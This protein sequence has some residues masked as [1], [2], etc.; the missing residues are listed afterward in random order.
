[1]RFPAAI[2]LLLA[3]P[4][5]AALADGV[6]PGWERSARAHLESMSYHFTETPDG[7]AAAA[8]HSQDIR[9]R[10]T[11]DGFRLVSRVHDAA[12]FEV[13]F[14]L[15]GYG[16][17]GAI[18]PV[19]PGT[20]KVHENRA[21]VARAG[22]PT[23]YFVNDERGF[24]H[25]YTVHE[26]PR[27]AKAR[28]VVLALDLATSL[29]IRPH[30]DGRTI[31]FARP[32]EGPAL[33]YTDLMVRDADG[34]ALPA[35]FVQA[36]T[37]LEIRYDDRGAAYPV[38]VDPIATTAWWTVE[39]T[40]AYDWLGWSA[41]A[42]G[43]LNGDGFSDIVIGITGEDEGSGDAGAAWVYYGSAAGLPSQFSPS[44]VGR[45]GLFAGNFGH[46]VSP[47]GDVNG[48]GYGDLIVGQPRDASVSGQRAFVYLGSAT[49]LRASFNNT[50]SLGDWKAVGGPT[51]NGVNAFGWSVASAG[52]VNGDG[53]DDVVVGAPA[54]SPDASTIAAGQALIW[55]GR[56]NFGDPALGT[57]DDGNAGNA[58]G[59]I[60]TG[61]AHRKL[62]QAVAGV[63]DVNAD[64]FDDVVVGAPG[65][66]SNAG[67]IILLTGRNTP[68]GGVN[69]SDQ[70]DG[71]AGSAFGQSVG[72]AG[73][74]NGDGYADVLVGAPAWNGG[75]GQVQLYAGAPSAPFLNFLQ[76]WTGT[77]PGDSLGL[78][79]HTAGDV[80]GDGLADVMIGRGVYKFNGTDP[81]AA[82]LYYGV[83]GGAPSFTPDWSVTGPIYNTIQQSSAYGFSVAS[84][85]DVDGDGY[86][87]FI[88]GAP[89]YGQSEWGHAYVYKGA[90]RAPQAATLSAEG[91]GQENVLG[92]STAIVGDVNWDGYD[93]VLVG[94]PGWDNGIYRQGAAFLYYGTANG[95]NFFPGWQQFGEYNEANFGVSVS[96][97]G[98]VNND[99][100]DDLIIGA[101]VNAGQGGA[102]VWH[103]S[104][105]GPSPGTYNWQNSSSNSGSYYG[106]WVAKAGDVN[107]DG[108]ADVAVGA[109]GEDAG[110]TDEGCAYVYLGSASGLGNA[111]VWKR[112]GNETNLQFGQN[113]CSAGDVNGDGL[114][115]I[116]VGAPGHDGMGGDPRG[117]AFIYNGIA[118]GVRTTP[119]WVKYGPSANSSFGAAASSAGDVNG[120]GYSDVLIG[121]PGHN[122]SGRVEVYHGGYFGP[123]QTPAWF[124]DGQF[125]SGYGAAVA[126]AGDM[127]G[128]GYSD[129]LVG[130]V[131]W[132]GDGG[133][134]CGRAIV[135]PGGPGGVSSTELWH[136]DGIQDFSNLG[137]MVSGGGDVNDDGFPDIVLGEPGYSGV[138]YRSGRAQ[139]FL[140]NGPGGRRLISQVQ[141]CF[142]LCLLQYVSPGGR[143]AAP[144]YS[145]VIIDRSPEGRAI[146][147]A[148][149]EVKTK[150][151]PFTGTGLLTS[152]S[153]DGSGFG[154]AGTP[155]NCP[156][157]QNPC[158]WRIRLT[159]KS[160][161]FPRSP[162]FSLP[163]NGPTESDVRMAG[164]VLAVDP[165]APA[166]ALSLAPS[167][168]P[169]QGP[170]HF[171]YALPEGAMVKLVVRDI[172]GRHVR[173]L[174][175]KWHAPGRYELTWDA[176]DEQGTRCAPGVYFG[177]V[178]AGA[179]RTSSRFSIVH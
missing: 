159:S 132:D 104:A 105:S 67:R 166:P 75:R 86:G 175:N 33:R 66:S 12:G 115:D 39:G 68:T 149:T 85:G 83:L 112:C 17:D 91:Q 134:D 120:D 18:R 109:P 129:I 5:S 114:D 24:E 3:L 36:G 38:D 102:Y 8:N 74:V 20:V 162:W 121:A 95:V 178:E 96:G 176:R 22:V 139:M 131:F 125:S 16:R 88:V 60:G 73:D 157:G 55:L 48:D 172:A 71:P 30:V 100:F 13:G 78:A 58:A 179:Q 31:A 113:V 111:E 10:V 116:I 110:L 4:V 106:Y 46:S 99:G 130:A 59:V 163:H 153:Q 43:D 81:G 11:G 15:A 117:R 124:Q 44:W 26:R 49:G 70:I 146:V 51:F 148:Q 7:M 57:S 54:F 140:G 154:W 141:D 171:A 103:G 80:N 27:G 167:P 160:P 34:D 47:A 37:R 165:G 35:H 135:Y 147:R 145:P 1:M 108:F 177:V 158:H 137:H 32:G 65:W 119:L 155:T 136:A 6:D 164:P 126:P 53:F 123:G 90:P 118:T 169:S 29:E 42:A 127:N 122:G 63:G 151:Q 64:G 84:A 28:E 82:Q 25:G 9:A 152:A 94:S 97:A 19:A 98:D 45:T 61:V 144:G 168:N 77:S 156:G 89:H 76:S 62:G 107:G 174:T 52:D 128:D 143:A 142:T 50:N 161:W 2:L 133:Y 93:D 138:D 173:T 23:E 101:H 79:V 92:W 150:A 40:G 87:E 41:K 170:T 21:E 72:P 14:R 69:I 56:S